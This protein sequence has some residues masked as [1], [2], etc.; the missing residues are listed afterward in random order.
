MEYMR[1]NAGQMK[2]PAPSG[3]DSWDK[4]GQGQAIPTKEQESNSVS[5]AAALKEL[6]EKKRE[7][8]ASKKATE[9]LKKKQDEL[10]AFQT[11]TMK[12][13]EMAAIKG[14]ITKVA[15]KLNIKETALEDIFGLVSSK[16]KVQGE[17]V[18]SEQIKEEDG[19]QE[20]VPVDAET[21]MTSWIEGKDYYVQPPQ[22]QPSG[23]PAVSSGPKPIVKTPVA[24]NRHG[25]PVFSN[26]DFFGRKV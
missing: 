5:L 20:I 18:F 16:F 23:I 11:Q 26:E 14:E 25:T 21:F 13:K 10:L 12:E 9:E 17:S 6:R 4:Q 2:Q 15:K 8:E 19:K 24:N 3:N 22:A 7:L 1:K